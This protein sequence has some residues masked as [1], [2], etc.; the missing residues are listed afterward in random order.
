MP[1]VRRASRAV[2]RSVGAWPAD[3]GAAPAADRAWCRAVRAWPPP[4][5]EARGRQDRP[6]RC[7]RGSR[8]LAEQQAAIAAAETEGIG[9]R[10][11]QVRA[12]VFQQDVALD[13][14]VFA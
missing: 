4:T 6:T 2:A 5:P 10:A 1:C 14:G 11:P 8:Q 7:T 3:R 13:S 12:A 9:E